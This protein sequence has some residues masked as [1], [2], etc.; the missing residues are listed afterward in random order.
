[1]I[2]D[3]KETWNL[4][5]TCTINE[6]HRLEARLLANTIMHNRERYEDAGRSFG[7]PFY[8]IGLLHYRE[9]SFNFKTWLANGDPL[10]NSDGKAIPTVHVPKGL[11]PMST[12]E[13]AAELSLRHE[14]WDKGHHWDVVNSLENMEAYNGTGYRAHGIHSPYIW[15]GTNQY[16][17]GMYKSDGVWSADAVDARCGV[18]P[19]MKT[20]KSV[21]GIDLN[22]IPPMSIKQT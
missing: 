17:H 10:W 20:L 19:V 9:A 2:I 7:I 16:S 13:S 5:D 22:E 4:W 1:M 14:G 6:N 18:A 21:Y 15:A 3:H 11:G 12:W 8:V